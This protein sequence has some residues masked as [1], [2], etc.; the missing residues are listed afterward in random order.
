MPACVTCVAVYI[1]LP[2]GYFLSNFHFFNK[3]FN[4]S[5]K[6]VFCRSQR[7]RTRRT[8]MTKIIGSYTVRIVG[9]SC[10]ARKCMGAMNVEITFGAQLVPKT[11]FARSAMFFCARTARR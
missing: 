4:C 9:C 10:G 8:R 2:V 6:I 5:V 7:I 1:V 3:I 11:C